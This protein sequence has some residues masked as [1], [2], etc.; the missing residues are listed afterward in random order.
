MYGAKG[1]IEEGG[2]V[3]VETEAVDEEGPE[4]VGN[5][6]ADIEEEGHCYPEISLWLEKEFVDVFHLEFAGSNT[7]LIGA[8]SFDGLVAFVWCEE[9]GVLYFRVELPV[10]EWCCHDGDEADEEEDDLP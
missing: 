9:A 4:G 5:G 10:D 7:S 3:F 2:G 1:H 6:C 8:E